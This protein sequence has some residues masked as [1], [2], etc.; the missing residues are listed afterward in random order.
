MTRLAWATDVHWSH[1]RGPARD[2]FGQQLY[3][4]KPDALL[5]TGDIAE[6]KTVRA[7][8]ADIQRRAACPVYYILGNHD[9]YGSSVLQVRQSLTDNPVDGA[10]YLATNYSTD[11]GDF[12]LVGVDGWGDMRNGNVRGTTVMLADYFHIA[13]LRMLPRDQLIARLNDLGD[14]DAKTLRLQLVALDTAN[15][16]RPVVVA[17]HVAP[18]PGAAWHLG[19]TSDAN[20]LPAFSCGAVGKVLDQVRRPLRVFCGHSHSGGEYRRGPDLVVR[21]GAAEYGAPA[22]LGVITANGFE[23]RNEGQ[24]P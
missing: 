2:E 10:T 5:I 6:A 17:T 9:Y 8:L 24:A 22:V 1:A 12:V 19:R 21:T 4:V 15:E 3:R 23:P 11:L 20:W 16:T 18:Y 7:A 14:L 13:D